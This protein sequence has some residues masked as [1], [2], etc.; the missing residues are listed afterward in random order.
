MPRYKFCEIAENITDK[1]MPTPEDK[2]LYIA[3]NNLD[4][5]TLTVPE[6][7]YKVDLNGTKLI[8]H[9]GDMLFGRREPQLKHAA[10]AP[11][12]GLF[13]AHGM[14]FHAKESVMSKEFF[15]FFISSDYF[16]DA[17]IRIAVGS[18][19]PTVNW[20]DLK[21]LEFTIP[22][23]QEQEKYAKL[24]WAI[25]RNKIAYKNLIAQTDELVKS[26]FV[27]MFGDP[28]YQTEN[29][30]TLGEHITLI[31][32][33]AFKSECFTPAGI[34]VIKIGNVNRADFSEGSMQFYDRDPSIER[35]IIKPGDLVISLTGTVGKDD[36]GNAAIVDDS[37]EEYYLNQRNAKLETH[38]EL[39]VVY[40]AHLLRNE[41][42]RTKLIQSGTGVR[43]C[44]LHN[45]DLEGLKFVLPSIEQ[46]NNYADFALQADKSKFAAQQALADLTASQKALMRQYLG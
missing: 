28:R 36:F 2:E 6:Y 38:P 11:H 21:D 5:E 42:I 31:N 8:M 10:I 44:H 25:I 15:P 12:D 14:I 45:K 32:G 40:L 13:S 7:G 39:N 9:K 1:R 34:P 37:Y 46:Q 35:Y 27:E 19:S 23:L 26:R 4:T 41:F 43:Q 3:P 20:R 16:F 30:T 33:F 22:T 17:A 24:L 18:L 29:L